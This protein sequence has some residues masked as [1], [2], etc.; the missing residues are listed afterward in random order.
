MEERN[1]MT[2]RPCLCVSLIG[3]AGSGKSTIGRILAKTLGWASLDTDYLMESIYACRLQDLTDAFPREIFLDIEKTVICSVKANRTVIATGGSAIYREAAMKY[4]ASLGPLVYLRASPDLVEA[5]IRLHPER[6]LV[7][8]P[9]QS[10]GS[11]Y[12]ER[13]PL[14]ARWASHCL[15]CGEMDARACAEW[16]VR[17]LR[18]ELAKEQDHGIGR[19]SEK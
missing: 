19:M 17:E 13:D 9:G 4:L 7:L 18:P 12:A 2:A 16:I 15:D 10:L 6:G 3:M 11:L 1:P 14:Y 5:R 8:G